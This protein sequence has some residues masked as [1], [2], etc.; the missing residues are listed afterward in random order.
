MAGLTGSNWSA[1]K[2]LFVGVLA[3]NHTSYARSLHILYWLNILVLACGC[4]RVQI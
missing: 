2:A 1:S 4:R 3:W